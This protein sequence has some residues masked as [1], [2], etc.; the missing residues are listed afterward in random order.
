MRKYLIGLAAVLFPALALYPQGDGFYLDWHNHVWLVGYFGEY[1]H[2]HGHMPAALTAPECAGM[3]Q[4]VFYGYFFYPILGLLSARLHP[5]IAVRLAALLLFAAQ[6][7]CTRQTCRRLG[8]GEGLAASI[9][10]LVVWATYPLTNLYN[11]SALTEFFAVGLLTCAVCSWFDLLIASSRASLWRRSLRFG[12]LFTLAAGTHPITALF[13]LPLLAIL[14]TAL[15]SWPARQEAGRPGLR[16]RFVALAVAGLLSAAALSPWLYAVRSLSGQLFIDGYARHVNEMSADIDHWLTR[17]FP[18]PFDRRALQRHPADVST[19]YLDAQINLPLLVLGVGLLWYFLRSLPARRLRAAAIAAVPILY[20]VAFL[21]LSL[22]PEAFRH[23]PEAFLIVQFLYR[24]VSYVNF[25]LLLVPLFLLLYAARSRLAA[26]AVP[27]TLLCFTLTLAGAGVVVK[28]VHAT[29]ARI[30]ENCHVQHWARFGRTWTHH[31]GPPH[32]AK[33]DADRQA[34]A[35]LPLSLFCTA[36]YTTPHALPR[37]ESAEEAAVPYIPL[38]V[39]HADG[40]FGVCQPVEICR[41]T[42]GYVGTEVVA[43]PWNRFLLDGIPVSE[44]QLRGWKSD[45]LIPWDAALRTAVLVPAGRHVLEHRFVPPPMWRR[46]HRG[47][48]GILLAWCVVLGVWAV[49]RT[50]RRRPATGQ[51]ETSAPRLADGFGPPDR[52]RPMAA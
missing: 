5:D 16:L 51:R 48:R 13:S 3:P 11:R 37:L 24:L 25:G 21:Y 47:G 40:Q 14:A 32:L 36:D 7:V 20:T 43:Y 23:L 22:R 18:L 34:L 26:P 1:F 52:Q 42:P 46:L 15:P 49:A 19:P 38:A 27:A 35:H 45:A 4:P 8:A 2:Q 9:A 6:Y 29:C 33:T 31:I 17:L 12:L 44:E 41:D 28:L 10:C 30:P 39:G 50:L